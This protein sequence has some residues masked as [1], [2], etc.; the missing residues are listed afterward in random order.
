MAAKVLPV[1]RTIAVTS[2]IISGFFMAKLTTIRPP[3]L[4]RGSLN[5]APD[6]RALNIRAALWPQSLKLLDLSPAVRLPPFHSSGSLA[7]LMAMRR[8]SSRVSKFA[9]AGRPGSSS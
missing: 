8:A 2:A 9:A 3:S 5:R 6:E 1:P 4:P 7:M